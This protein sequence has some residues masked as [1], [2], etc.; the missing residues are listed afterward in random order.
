MKI[1]VIL[2]AGMLIFSGCRITDR[3]DRE[4]GTD[5]INNPKSE[6]SVD[7]EKLPVIAFGDPVFNFGLISEGEVIDHTFSFKNTG[8]SPLV[9]SHIEGSCGCTVMRDWPKEPIAPGDSGEISVEFNSKNKGGKQNV[10]IRVLANT[11]PATTVLTMEGEI[12]SVKQ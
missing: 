9:I 11:S 3:S 5:L 8:K 7:P 1:G 4:V 2:F 6:F 10:A 12:A